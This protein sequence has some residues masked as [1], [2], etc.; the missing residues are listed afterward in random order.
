MK[1]MV[2]IAERRLYRAFIEVE[3]ESE[4]EI[5]DMRPSEVCSLAAEINE[6]DWELSEDDYPYIHDYE[7]IKESEY[8]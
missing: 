2:T 5:A 7:V 6:D 3:A 1:F 8:D 4:E